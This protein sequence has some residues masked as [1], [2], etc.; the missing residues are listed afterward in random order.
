MSTRRIAKTQSRFAAR[1][2]KIGIV[3]SDYHEAAARGLLEGARRCLTACGLAPDSAPVVQVPGAFEIP[4]AVSRLLALTQPPL[5][6]VV[7]LG[8]LMRGDTIHFEVLSHE[9][10]RRLESIAVRTG[11]PV[12]FGVLT[13]DTESQARE[14]SGSGVSNK[15]WEAAEAALRMAA[16]FR[17]W[18]GAPAGGVPARAPSRTRRRRS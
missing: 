6:A 12:A 8:V 7:T 5:D 18:D 4:Q 9:V 13:V 3:W 1:G 10:C 11:V 15:G 16:L 2:L 14:R 17:D